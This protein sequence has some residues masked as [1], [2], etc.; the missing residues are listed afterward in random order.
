MEKAL[1]FTPVSMPMKDLYLGLE[2]GVIDGV[3]LPR[4]ILVSRR[5]GAI[6][7]YV[8]DIVLGH[9]TFFVVMLAFVSIS[10]P[11]ALFA[12]QT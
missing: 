8:T 9:D 5:L 4:E 6:T 7:K 3:A 1:D 12:R 11:L 10:H 2:K